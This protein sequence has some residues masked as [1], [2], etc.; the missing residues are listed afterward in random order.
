MPTYRTV[1]E[2]IIRE[3]RQTFE[4]FANDVEL[5]AREHKEPGTLGI[6]HLQRLVAGRRPDGTPLSP[7][8]PTTARLLEHMLNRSIYE[9]LSRPDQSLSAD[10]SVDEFRRRLE[11]SSQVDDTMLKILR[12]ELDD[13]RRIDR[14]HGGVAAYDKV[15]LKIDQVAELLTH[16]VST[17]TREPLAALLSELC[18]LAGW[19][20]LDLGRV[21]D[22]WHYYENATRAATESRIPSFIGLAKVGRA[23]VMAEIGKTDIAVDLAMETHTA[24]EQRCSRL[25]RA[26]L[27]AATGEVLATSG[28]GAMSL[29]TF[30]KA[31]DLL[32][33]GEIDP[34]DPYVALDATHLKRWHGYALAKFQ[35]AEAVNELMNA[36]RG[37]DSAFVRAET[38]LRVDL[39]TA[40]AG[41]GEQAEARLQVSH[42]LELARRIN[43]IRQIRRIHAL[44]AVRPQAGRN[45]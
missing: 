12:H 41:Q 3:R 23:L 33:P 29:R 13:I 35:A 19:Q 43:S 39:A 28:Q 15:R 45:L 14:E 42:A 26:W 4:E 40:L 1:L 24:A 8:K 27:T 38:S 22:S 7:L 6:R 25:V 34:N 37:L 18:C 32:R 16:S 11:I 9:L 5:F 20:T 2:Q 44:K 36:L 10:D 17:R 30:D 21:K 31:F